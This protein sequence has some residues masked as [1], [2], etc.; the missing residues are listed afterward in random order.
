MIDNFVFDLWRIGFIVLSSGAILG[1]INGL[2]IT[3]YVSSLYLFCFG[4]LVGCDSI[5][6][7]DEDE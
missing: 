7:F 6:D 3:C 5:F 2:A 1:A 4:F